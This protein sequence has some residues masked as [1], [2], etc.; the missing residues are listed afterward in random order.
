MG[1]E[2][3]RVVIEK[4]ITTR[5]VFCR[6]FLT[7]FI[8]GMDAGAEVY[9]TDVGGSRSLVRYDVPCGNRPCINFLGMKRQAWVPYF[10]GGSYF[11]LFSARSLGVVFSELFSI[12][13]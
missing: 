12:L 4:G 11:Y 2:E 3:H 10:Q 8:T 5:F 9:I 7:P 13:K 6:S 1:V